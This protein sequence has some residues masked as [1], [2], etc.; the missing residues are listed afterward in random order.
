M[1]EETTPPNSVAK[2]NRSRHKS[3]N[4]TIIVG[5]LV[6]VLLG[7]LVALYGL[8]YLPGGYKVAVFA[9]TIAFFLVVIFV[10][11]ALYW[12]DWMF[13]KVFNQ[14]ESVDGFF[15]EAEKATSLI[16]KGIVDQSLS[17]LPPEQREQAKNHAPKI[18]NYLVWGRIRKWWVNLLIGIFV[19]IGGL[20]TTVLLVKQNDL[21]ETQ[22]RKI[23]NQNAL[24]ESQRRS[25]LILLMGNILTDLSNEIDEQEKNSFDDQR[26]VNIL[27]S[28]GYRLSAPLIGRIASIS[29]GFIP[30][31][32]LIDEELT[33]KK[34]SPERAQLL[35]ALVGSNLSE[36]TLMKIYL[37]TSFEH[38]YLDGAKLNNSFLRGIDLSNSLLDNAV[39]NGADLS[40]A[41]L[42]SVSMRR[43]KMTGTRLSGAKIID[44]DLS[45]SNIFVADFSMDT[46]PELIRSS[47]YKS[48]TEMTL[49]RYFGDR[50]DVKK[51]L[52][53]RSKT[54]KTIIS[55]VNFSN[56]SISS[57]SIN[58]CEVD[59]TNFSG[60]IFSNVNLESTAFNNCIFY[61]TKIELKEVLRASKFYNSK[62]LSMGMEENIMF[63]KPCLLIEKGCLSSKE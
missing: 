45:E 37:T 24:I 44:A 49:N 42:V 28:V 47:N 15:V 9:M 55:S 31:P 53:F 54:Q 12:R 51:I 26:N 39:L 40:R 10:L 16:V 34:Y 4:P 8:D 61:K 20:A 14:T 30:Y 2:I 27:D 17:T 60:A 38:S 41:K 5:V 50:F 7:L 58:G 33:E 52:E 56:A 23:D 6:G 29:Q 19:G 48:R 18:I 57:S 21:L 3:N 35:L 13:K 32:I 22:N 63:Q 25:S 1:R 59:Q 46:L 36:N 43:S 62:G 11:A